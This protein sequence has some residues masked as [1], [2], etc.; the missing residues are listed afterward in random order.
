MVASSEPVVFARPGDVVQ[1]VAIA[2]LAGLVEEHEQFDIAEFF[3]GSGAV[4]AGLHL[5]VQALSW[6][7]WWDLGQIL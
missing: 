4:A 3:A 2:F 5:Q 6:P 7:I 1:L